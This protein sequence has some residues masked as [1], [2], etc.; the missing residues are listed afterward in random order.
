MFKIIFRYSTCVPC[1]TDGSQSKICS[2]SCINLR[3]RIKT[4]PTFKQKHFLTAIIQLINW[5]LSS[6]SSLGL[7]REYCNCFPHFII[8]HQVFHYFYSSKSHPS[9]LLDGCY[10]QFENCFSYIA[11]T[12][13]IS[14]R[15]PVQVTQTDR[16]NAGLGYVSENINTLGGYR[17]RESTSVESRLQ[18]VRSH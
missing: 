2:I 10:C 15:N 1:N 12:R 9:Q 7:F 14:R 3:E 13:L 16:S 4:S 11:I 17:R 8:Y 6:I 18:V 5:Y